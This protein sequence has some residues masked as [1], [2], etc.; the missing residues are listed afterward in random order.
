MR[1]LVLTLFIL[2]LLPVAFFRPFVGLM[3]WAWISYM[4]PHRLTWS[5]AY[6]FR[7]NLIVALITMLGIL[8][9]RQTRL[10]IPLRST[11]V[12]LIIFVCWT[13]LSAMNGLRPEAA[14]NQVD[15]FLR[16]QIMVVATML[17]VHSRKQ[18]IGIVAVIAFSI[19]FYGF[20]GGFFTLNTGGR[21]R[22]M[23]PEQSFFVDN[24]HFAAAMIMTIPLIYFLYT[25]STHRVL[26]LLMLATIGFSLLAVL[27]SYSRGGFVGLAMVGL[28]FWWK[29]RHKILSLL[30]MSLLAVSTFWAM[31]ASWHDRMSPVIDAGLTY[32]NLLDIEEKKPD[33]TKLPIPPGFAPKAIATLPSSG[34]HSQPSFEILEMLDEDHELLQ[35]KSVTGRLNAWRLALLVANDNPILGGGFRTFDQSTFDRY[36]PGVYRHAAHSIYFEILAE[37]GYVGFGIWLML[38]FSGLHMARWIIRKTRNEPEMSW[39]NNLARMYQV[40]MVGYYAAGSFLSMGYFDLPYHLMGILI[41]T[42]INVENHYKL[43]QQNLRSSPRASPAAN[44]GHKPMPWQTGTV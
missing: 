13:I 5:F 19:G 3:M 36:T 35:D 24:N 12:L 21:H 9:H 22:V 29:S 44:T 33:A 23:G 27:G 20:K 7:F 10:K 16:I 2:G 40:S 34:H 32:L 14:M 42:K 11:S 31:P 39:A 18:I 41:M 43:K 30:A 38:Q 6:N 17:L 25:H 8:F 26:R 37:Q 1:D 4:N 28:I 15:I